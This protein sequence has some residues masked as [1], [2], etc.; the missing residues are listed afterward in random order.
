MTEDDDNPHA[1][2]TDD[3]AEGDIQRSPRSRRNAWLAL[4]ALI[5]VGG[6]VWHFARSAGSGAKQ[7]SSRQRAATVGIAR[8]VRSDMPVAITAIGTV[9]PI[10]TATVRTQ[11]AG[12]LFSLHFTEGQIV[13]KGELI[14]QIDPRPY[15]LALSQARANLARDQAQLALANVD[16]RRYQTLL[17]QDSIARQQVETQAATVKQ[18]EGTVTADRAAIGT[19]QLN[20]AYTAIRAPVSG[21][22][23][24]RQADLG[25]YLTPS[26]ANGIAVITQ[27]DPID[28]NFALPQGQL[29]GIAEAAGR[30]EG[31]PVTVSGQNG[32]AVLA[33]G[34]FLTLDNQIDTTSGTVKAKARFPNP[35]GA[36]FPNQFVN[37]SL[38]ASTVHQAVVVPVSA[39]RHGANGDFI[40]LLQPDRTV[41]LQTV[42]TGPSDTTR[43]A[44]LSGVE[45]GQTVITEGAD[46][47]DDGSHVTLANHHGSGEQKGQ[48]DQHHRHGKSTG[49]DQ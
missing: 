36:L 46:S 4:L 34:R 37:V 7:D 21:R 1:S 14:A 33:Q 35:A 2:A 32:G 17:S 49:T 23:G 15:Q 28:V 27:T 9:Q 10:T 47:L 26:D 13:T 22:I 11:L 40:F 5:I 39:V 45:A 31:L 24:L 8:A 48:A 38:L 29:P 3:P 18:S 43:I 41:K 12:I 16:L 30:G 6:L 19:A 42:R 44:I 20:L 25:N